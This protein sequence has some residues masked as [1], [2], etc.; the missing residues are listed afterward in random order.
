M[1]EEI[2]CGPTREFGWQTQMIPKSP[3]G[4]RSTVNEQ[5]CVPVRTPNL[6]RSRQADLSKGAKRIARLQTRLGSELDLTFIPEYVC[7]QAFWAEF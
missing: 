7:V 1:L 6:F 5:R 2:A 3:S 4:S